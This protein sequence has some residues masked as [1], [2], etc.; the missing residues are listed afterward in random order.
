[1]RRGCARTRQA[2]HL[3]LTLPVSNYQKGKSALVDCLVLAATSYLV[4]GRSNLSDASLAFNP[5]LPY[6]FWPD[7][8][9][10]ERRG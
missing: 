4:K 6:S 7:V 8:A 3:D 10:L 1:M 5:N 9:A 2:V